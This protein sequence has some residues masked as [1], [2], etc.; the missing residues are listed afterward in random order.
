[1]QLSYPSFMCEGLFRPSCAFSHHFLSAPEHSHPSRK[2]LDTAG[3][4]VLWWAYLWSCADNHTIIFDT[5]FSLTVGHGSSQACN[6][7][8]P[9]RVFPVS[10]WHAT[11]T[12][13]SANGPHLNVW[14]FDIPAAEFAQQKKRD[15]L[16]AVGMNSACITVSVIT[17]WVLK[18]DAAL[19]KHRVIQYNVIV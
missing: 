6:F 18:H 2:T 12:T 10:E 5:S 19:F 13:S 14:G 17:V 16:F 1:M 9:F 8:A 7:T 3:I 4:L 15:G 11:S